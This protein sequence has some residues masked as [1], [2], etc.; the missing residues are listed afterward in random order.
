MADPYYDLNP[1]FQRAAQAK[2]LGNTSGTTPTD[3]TSA[4]QANYADQASTT[5][6]NEAVYLQQEQINNQTAM[7]NQQIQQSKQMVSA[8]KQS[9][10]R[11]DI[12]GGAQLAGGAYKVGKAAYDWYNKPGS[13]S[14]TGTD[15]A[16]GTG[17]GYTEG[18]ETSTG[19]A[20]GT[21][22]GYTE[23]I[24]ATGLG[25]GAGYTEGLGTT[26]YSGSEGDTGYS[27][28]SGGIISGADWAG[29]GL[30]YAGSQEGGQGGSALKAMGDTS[31]IVSSFGSGGILG[32]IATG[33]A[34]IVKTVLCTELAR[35]GLLDKEV[36]RTEGIYV[37]RH[38]TEEE[39][40]GYRIIADPLV[41]LM[42]K[43]KVFTLMIAPFIRAFAYEM[44][45]RVDS[46]IKGSSLGKF[47]LWS[48]LPLC[49]KVYSLKYWR[50]SCRV[51]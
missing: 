47:I 13:T 7:T 45:H 28:G 50:L 24:G 4:I 41:T 21:G 29:M 51:S 37:S 34:K 26:S 16:L 9:A 19:Q 49:R 23:G 31:E 36:L 17:G 42:Q 10:L 46:N 38:I 27:P 5:R 32:V 18:I 40:S 8:S 1:Y 14:P 6:A 2:A 33:I 22:A 20:L 44:A 30:D 48:G 15:T 39:Y 25:T 11:Q 35:Q 12:S 3:L 43:S